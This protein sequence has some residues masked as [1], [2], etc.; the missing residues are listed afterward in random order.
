MTRLRDAW[1]ILTGRTSLTA[2]YHHGINAGQ[3][4]AYTA[5]AT[6]GIVTSPYATATAVTR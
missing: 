1:H 3:N 2:M 5:F 6:H 4:I